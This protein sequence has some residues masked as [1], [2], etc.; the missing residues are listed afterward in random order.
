LQHLP[1]LPDFAGN[2]LGPCLPPRAQK[3]FFFSGPISLA[4]HV[5]CPL[6]ALIVKVLAAISGTLWVL[7]CHHAHKKFLIFFQSR[8]ALHAMYHVHCLLSC[9]PPVLRYFVCGS[10]VCANRLVPK[11]NLLLITIHPAGSP[12]RLCFRRVWFSCA[13]SFV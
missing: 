7:V 4:R 2:A 3:V 6:C 13:R 11:L 9:V 12:A 1:F 8:S 5:P 10:H